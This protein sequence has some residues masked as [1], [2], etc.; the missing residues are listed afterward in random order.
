[1]NEQ[2]LG[3]TCHRIIASTE[4]EKGHLGT[5]YG[6]SPGSVG[7]VPCG[8]DLDLFRPADKRAA[9][10]K[11]GFDQNES[12]LLYVGRFVPSKGADRMPEVM[13]HLRRDRLFRLLI[14]GGDNHHTPGTQALKKL[15]RQ[16]GVQDRITFL[17]R[18]TQEKLPNYYNA[19]DLLVVP[20]RY[21]SFGLVA[22]ESLACGT[23]V[24][25]TRVGAME[26]ILRDW[27][28]GHL[29][30]NGSPRLLAEGIEAVVSNS[31]G[32]S[33][34]AISASVT[35]FSWTDVTSALMAEYEAVLR[36]RKDEHGEVSYD[37]FN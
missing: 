4:K 16:H 9:R 30:R 19:A 26:K 12:I 20:S 17:G 23:P 21:E 14:V 7:V 5:Y 10:R 6:I 22:L 34:D 25:A 32:L 31:H 13:S 37:G 33:A 8:V 18:V 35:G 1:M 28:T 36:Q 24:V 15:S 3:E 11:L 2:Q 29:V 27:E